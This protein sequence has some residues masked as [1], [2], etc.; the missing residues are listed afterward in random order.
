MESICRCV[1]SL[2][3]FTPLGAHY[4]RAGGMQG[5]CISISVMLKIVPDNSCSFLGKDC[6]LYSGK[7]RGAALLH[8]G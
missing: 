2:I 1:E 4:N 3:I 7:D 5:L 6:L 8:I